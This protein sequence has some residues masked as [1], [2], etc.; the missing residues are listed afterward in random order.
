M[1]HQKYI[2]A[3]L[4][5]ILL[6]NHVQCGLQRVKRIVRGSAVESEEKLSSAVSLQYLN[7]TK[8]LEHFCG[9]T[10][11]GRGW[12]LTASHC[13]TLIDYEKHELYAEIGRKDLY[14]NPEKLV[15][16]EDFYIIQFDTI[17]YANDIAM[18][19]L[20]EDH[21]ELPSNVILPQSTVP[22]SE[23]SNCSI[24]GYGSERFLQ[25]IVASF[26]EAPIHIL[27]AEE[28]EE[29]LVPYAPDYSSGMFCAGGGLEDACQGDSGSGLI[30]EG[31]TLVGIVSY[32]SS[33]GIPG[34]PGVYTDVQHHLQWINQVVAQPY[35]M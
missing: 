12:I 21:R 33:C 2:L 10:Y 22:I 7:S 11:V 32:G 3:P 30:C 28:C 31:N 18:I 13:L 16:L 23:H 35:E 5:I 20:P 27:P 29:A 17:T 24:F 9:G 15:K 25:D 1:C 26:R 19:R 8:Q 6:T 34:L 4:L 14:N